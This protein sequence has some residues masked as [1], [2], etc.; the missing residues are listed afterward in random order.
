MENQ[1]KSSAAL[2][3]E[4][5]IGQAASCPESSVNEMPPLNKPFTYTQD[6]LRR[7]LVNAPLDKLAY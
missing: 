4:L 5:V 3:T 2:L 1:A 6:R 7:M